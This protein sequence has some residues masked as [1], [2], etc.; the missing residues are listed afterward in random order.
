MIFLMIF[1]SLFEIIGGHLN[2]SLFWSILSPNGGGEPTGDVSQAINS[3]LAI[4]MI[5][6][7]VF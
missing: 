1:V 6:K 3:A 7:T 5:L 2:H 4:L